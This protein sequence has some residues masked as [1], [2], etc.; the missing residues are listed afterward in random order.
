[1]A[2]PGARLLLLSAEMLLVPVSV[3]SFFGAATSLA[4]SEDL[5]EGTPWPAIPGLARSDPS[6]PPSRRAGGEWMPRLPRPTLRN[7]SGLAWEVAVNR[8][9]NT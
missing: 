3:W 5:R 4:H 9:R 7:L 6:P 2:L 8:A 1:M